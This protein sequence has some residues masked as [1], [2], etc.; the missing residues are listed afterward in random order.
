[1]CGVMVVDIGRSRC[2]NL[3]RDAYIHDHSLGYHH[4]YLLLYQFPNSNLFTYRLLSFLREATS[5]TY[6]PRVFFLIYL[7]AIYFSFAFLFRS[8]KPKIQKYYAALYFIR[9]LLFQRTQKYLAALFLSLF[10]FVFLSD[11]FMKSPTI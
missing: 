6:G 10:Y 3:G 8:I 11:L 2:N 4:N 9:D 7:L 5:E 1:M